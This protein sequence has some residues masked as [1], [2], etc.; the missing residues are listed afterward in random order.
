[1]RTVVGLV[2]LSVCFKNVFLEHCVPLMVEHVFLRRTIDP[3]GQLLCRKNTDCR[4][5]LLSVFQEHWSGKHCFP[6]CWTDYTSCVGPSML[7]N[8]LG[9]II[10][11]PEQCFPADQSATSCRLCAAEETLRVSQ[12]VAAVL[13]AAQ[14]I[15]LCA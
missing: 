5:C 13:S 12:T 14:V 15:A 8:T 1:M 3:M 9:P 2:C 10:L 7:G 11:D 6:A 4:L